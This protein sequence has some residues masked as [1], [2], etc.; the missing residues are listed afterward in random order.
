MYKLECSSCGN[1]IL[2]NKQIAKATCLK[3]RGRNYK[4]KN[5]QKNVYSRGAK[6]YIG[7]D[8]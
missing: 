1:I 3:C 7:F 2:R 4:L 5:K 8:W 6:E